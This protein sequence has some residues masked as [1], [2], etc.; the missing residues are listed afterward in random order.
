M[1]RN[2]FG[3]YI[4]SGTAV[5]F[6]SI[7]RTSCARVHSMTQRKPRIVR[8]MYSSGFKND[9]GMNNKFFARWFI[10]VALFGTAVFVKIAHSIKED[11]HNTTFKN[12]NKSYSPEEWQERIADIKKKRFSF[13]SGEEFYLF[14]FPPN[15]SNSA[16]QLVKK[17]G[18]Q[19]SV[20]V[21]DL[22]QLIKEQLEDPNSQFGRLLN[23]TL[24]KEDDKLDAC[25]YKFTYVLAPGVFTQ[26][27]KDRAL[28]LREENSKIS[29]YVVLNYP[30]TIEEAVKFEQKVATVTKLLFSGK[31]PKDNN[32][33]DYFS[34]VDKVQSVDKIPKMEPKLISRDIV[35]EKLEQISPADSLDE[36]P[37]ENSSMI[38]RAQ[39]KLRQMGEPIR[40]YGENDKDVIDRLSQ[41]IKH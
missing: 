2:F 8:R 24:D 14:P 39:Y 5:P 22:N 40:R 7:K 33:V 34:T 29:R 13:T 17:L 15:S 38:R 1:L 41:L 21:I 30:N 32:I 12:K 10:I 35:P 23:D 20:G 4:S 28:K 36:K 26:L 6:V 19:E 27:V 3:K 31:E 16:D 25:H 11:K 9:D 18:G 37:G